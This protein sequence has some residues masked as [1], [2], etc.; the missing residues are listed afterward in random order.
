MTEIVQEWCEQHDEL[1]LDNGTIKVGDERAGS[2][3]DGNVTIGPD[4]GGVEGEPVE[5]DDGWLIVEG[6]QA[7][8]VGEDNMHYYENART[9]YDGMV[10]WDGR[11]AVRPIRFGRVEIDGPLPEE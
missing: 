1:S 2:V 11:F 5:V 7:C 4:D 8:Y 9:V 3:R 6:S 10:A